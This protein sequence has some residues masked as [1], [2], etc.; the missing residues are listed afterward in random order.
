MSS[1][2]RIDACKPHGG[3][4]NIRYDIHEWLGC[5]GFGVCCRLLRLP[6]DFRDRVWRS[7]RTQ[8]QEAESTGWLGSTIFGGVSPF[9]L[10]ASFGVTAILVS[11]LLGIWLGNAALTEQ[12]T[13]N[14]FP[15]LTSSPE[16]LAP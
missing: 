4:W 7:I 8:G 10:A 12:T 2:V 6:S 14:L 13:A 9:R 15:T 5:S 16:L 11:S 1:P 3:D